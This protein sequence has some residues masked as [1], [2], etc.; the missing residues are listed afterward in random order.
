MKNV[1]LLLIF[2]PIF[3][4]CQDQVSDLKYFGLYSPTNLQGKA[5]FVETNGNQYYLQESDSLRIFKIKNGQ[6]TL[7]SSI[8][9]MD[10]K[11]LNFQDLH[12]NRSHLNIVD[13]KYYRTFNHG[14][15][16]I[17]IEDGK[18]LYEFDLKEENISFM[19]FFAVYE[20]Y[21]FYFVRKANKNVHYS[22]DI[23]TGIKKQIDLPTDNSKYLNIENQLVR[24]I[25]NKIHVFDLV[26]QKDTT[27]ENIS[28]IRKIISY[29]AID[30]SYY[31]VNDSL[32]I[33][34][35]HRNLKVQSTLCTLSPHWSLDY[36]T[37]QNKRL[38]AYSFVL[39]TLPDT[40]FIKNIDTGIDEMTIVD[41]FTDGPTPI[42]KTVKMDIGQRNLSIIGFIQEPEFAD[43][44]IRGRYF[45]INHPSKTYTEIVGTS[46][47]Q[48]NSSFVHNNI[49][50]FIGISSSFW[51]DFHQFYMQNLSNSQKFR[52]LDS[53]NKTEFILGYPDDKRVY[54]ASNDDYENPI[55]HA[56]DALGNIED[57]KK[58][59]FTQN[60]GINVVNTVIPMKDRFYFSNHS[61]F[62]STFENTVNELIYSNPSTIIR[63]KDAHNY[64]QYNEYIVFGTFENNKLK[65]LRSNTITGQKDSVVTAYSGPKNLY[66]AGPF[67]FI[68]RGF[69]SNAI[70]YYDVKNNTLKT[71]QGLKDLTASQMT[72]GKSSALY[73][74]KYET[75]KLF[76]IDYEKSSI[77]Q[78]PLFS[79]G[80]SHI[81]AGPDDTYYLVEYTNSKRRITSINKNFDTTIIYEGIGFYSDIPYN[82]NIL[83]KNSSYAYFLLSNGSNSKLLIHHLEKVDLIQLPTSSGTYYDLV[84]AENDIVLIKSIN[85]NKTNYFLQL[86][87]D[88][89][90][91]LEVEGY[92]FSHMFVNDGVLTMIFQRYG[93]SLIY[94]YDRNLNTQT[95]WQLTTSHCTNLQVLDGIDFGNQKRLLFGICNQQIFLWSLDMKTDSLTLFSNEGFENDLFNIDNI[96]EFRGYIYFTGAKKEMFRQWFR[97]KKDTTS[98]TIETIDKVDFTFKVYPSP[99]TTSIIID[100]DCIDL[101]IIDHLGKI[102]MKKDKYFAGEELNIQSLASG[103]YYLRASNTNGRSYIKNFIKME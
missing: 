90:I 39:D 98:S 87:M 81:I 95:K 51:G 71:F 22:L 27:L 12:L 93:N 42:L 28:K 6:F 96:F 84:H 31:L 26:T 15:Q 32:R 35:L 68:N 29:S 49:L 74:D 25:D 54:L 99:S 101:E 23:K 2:I 24:L 82:N 78:G 16:I 77:I 3:S 103:I 86:G 11:Y 94:K 72:K 58:L 48:D 75:Y 55:I 102:L 5:G 56:L 21:V 1:I 30:S 38:F 7:I 89:L 80:I 73:Y 19:Y 36:L 67:L 62:Y 100:I 65:I 63:N 41:D 85:Q 13:G 92:S 60:V 8:K 69:T 10:H 52:P 44:A 83:S 46:F 4:F 47:I 79:K 33:L 43:T 61:G 34:K 17:S 70:Q 66:G 88:K 59:D 50:Y 53:R 18:I 97:V 14:L 45:A 91:P 76:L 9:K 64:T 57:I 40:M 20:N 37:I